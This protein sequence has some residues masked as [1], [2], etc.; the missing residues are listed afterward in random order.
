MVHILRVIVG[1]HGTIVCRRHE[2]RTTISKDLSIVLCCVVC[3]YIRA[4][5]AARHIVRV[6]AVHI[7]CVDGSRRDEAAPL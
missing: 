2:L 1:R 5:G 6:G 3:R 7:S 4:A